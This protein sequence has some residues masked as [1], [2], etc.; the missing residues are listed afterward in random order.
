MEEETELREAQPKSPGFPV[1]MLAL[2]YRVGN[3][4]P[5]YFIPALVAL[6]LVAVYLEKFAGFTQLQGEKKN[7]D[8]CFFIYIAR[9]IHF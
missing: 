2:F 3:S 9:F 8:V 1:T 6:K 4:T 7:C 5:P